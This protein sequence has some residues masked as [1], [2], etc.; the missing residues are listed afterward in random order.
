M[1]PVILCTFLSPSMAHQW[2]LRPDCS[3]AV[4]VKARAPTSNSRS[5]VMAEMVEDGNFACRFLS[6][7][8][9]FSLDNWSIAGT[10]GNLGM[11]VGVGTRAMFARHSK[12]RVWISAPEYLL[13]WILP[14]L[15]FSWECLLHVRQKRHRAPD[16]KTAELQQE[17]LCV[18]WQWTTWSTGSRRAEPYFIVAPPGHVNIA[19]DLKIKDTS[20]SCWVFLAHGTTQ[21]ASSF[22]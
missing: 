11:C 15:P 8:S 6:L 14:S 12:W 7:L 13:L 2:E 10:W 9:D 18:H 19:A 17:W 1:T 16:T 3:R 20:G 21:I 22:F 4:L 5:L